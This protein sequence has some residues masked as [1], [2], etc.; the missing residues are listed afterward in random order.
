VI[1]ERCRAFSET[2]RY[3]AD[4]GVTSAAADERRVAAAGDET[5]AEHPAEAAQRSILETEI[6]RVERE[7]AAVLADIRDLTANLIE[8][9]AMK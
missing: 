9:R 5:I 3:G 8:S 7:A 2:S 6:G 4:L 1:P